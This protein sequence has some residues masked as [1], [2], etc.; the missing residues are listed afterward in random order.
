MR[1]LR[2]SFV[3]LIGFGCA[4]ESCARAEVHRAALVIA[5]S[6]YDNATLLP[7]PV[8]DGRAVAGALRDTGFVVS[9]GYDLSVKQMRKTLRDFASGLGVGDVAVFYFAGHGFANNGTDYLVPKDATLTSETQIR[10]QAISLDEIR[11]ALV[12]AHGQKFIILDACRDNPFLTRM[13]AA[14][15]RSRAFGPSRGF[16]LVTP[17]DNTLVAY[18]A[19]AGT[20]AGDG[21]GDHSPFSAAL[22]RRMRE[23]GVDARIMFGEVRDDVNSTSGGMQKPNYFS[24]LSGEQFFFVPAASEPTGHAGKRTPYPGEA[25]TFLSCVAESNLASLGNSSKI[26]LTFVNRAAAER[27]LYWLSFTGERTF[28][29]K[30]APGDQWAVDTYLQHVWVIA[31]EQAVCQSLYVTPASG[32][33]V[34]LK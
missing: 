31:N 10:D 18:S 20:T 9:E 6:A 14:P 15:G 21:E 28:F 30:L 25:G 22:V 16:V 27:D 1:W 8:R 23:P 4:V 2:C 12:K 32:A 17:S 34:T 11:D 13:K 26:S 19:E 7:N 24:E 5:V 29:E 3:L 33:V